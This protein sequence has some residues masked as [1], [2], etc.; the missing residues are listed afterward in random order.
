LTTASAKA[1][2][3]AMTEI[4]YEQKRSEIVEAI[5]QDQAEMDAAL[6][7]LKVAADDTIIA[8]RQNL[9]LRHLMGKR[10]VVFMASAL[11]LGLLVGMTWRR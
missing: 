7:E 5:A 1:Q 8:V 11:A 3:I 10:P 4:T 6:H 9:D 2:E